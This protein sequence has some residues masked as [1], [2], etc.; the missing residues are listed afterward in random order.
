M[1][2]EEKAR[3]FIRRLCFFKTYAK[4]NVQSI[5]TIVLGLFSVIG[6]WHVVVDRE[7]QLSAQ[8]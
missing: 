1:K 4:V 6:Y 2:K 5:E 8:K 7:L 3:L